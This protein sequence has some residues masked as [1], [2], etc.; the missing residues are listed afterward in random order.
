M[1]EVEGLTKRYRSRVAVDDVTFTV[2]REREEP[3]AGVPVGDD[4]RHDPVAGSDR[5]TSEPGI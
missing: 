4:R 3:A 1:I 5:P 2:Q